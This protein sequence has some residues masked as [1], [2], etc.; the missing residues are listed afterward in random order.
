MSVWNQVSGLGQKKKEKLLCKPE[1]PACMH[2]FLEPRVPRQKQHGGFRDTSWRTTLKFL[3][4]WNLEGKKGSTLEAT[5][6]SSVTH[7]KMCI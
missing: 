6:L 2:I 3:S 5:D 4:V 1:A 7:Q